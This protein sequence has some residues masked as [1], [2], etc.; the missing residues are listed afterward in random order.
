M[1]G[2][3]RWRCSW[4]NDPSWQKEYDGIGI[5]KVGIEETHN[6][7]S[8]FIVVGQDVKVRETREEEMMMTISRCMCIL[9]VVFKQWQSRRRRF[10]A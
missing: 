8:A 6:T 1:M 3:G 4:K 10:C 9:D 7:D 2:R 5:L